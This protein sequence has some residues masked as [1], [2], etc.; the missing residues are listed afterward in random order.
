MRPY[1]RRSARYYDLMLYNEVRQAPEE[2][3]FFRSLW[4][5]KVRS[6][7]D[8]GCG[9]GRLSILL[10][11]R[12]DVV[13][14][15][16]S[17]EMLEVAKSKRHGSNPAFI[18]ADMRTYK[19]GKKFDAAVCGSN[20]IGHLITEKD[21]LKA[22][23]NIKAALK[24]GGT[25][26]FDMWDVERWKRGGSRGGK[27]YVLRRAYSVKGVSMEWTETAKVDRKRGLWWWRK[28]AVVMDHGRK[29]KISFGGRLRWRPQDE[30]LGLLRK[31]G[32]S[33]ARCVTNRAFKEKLYFAA[34]R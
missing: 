22:F 29:V 34:V 5:S 1:T 26:V 10:A 16:V 8:A 9:T 24:P 27:G 13:G 17:P 18:L 14:I 30:W 15:D 7:L 25:F 31:A 28:H 4:G 6:V 3:A 11:Q 33:K 2:A 21:A 12:Y 23:A 20:T 19:P 32:F